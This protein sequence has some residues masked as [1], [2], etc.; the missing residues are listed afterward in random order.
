VFVLSLVGSVIAGVLAGLWAL[1]SVPGVCAVVWIFI[2]LVSQDYKVVDLVVVSSEQVLE[3]QRYYWY[4]A[5]RKQVQTIE[6]RHILRV[7][8]RVTKR[9]VMR[10]HRNGAQFFSHFHHSYSVVIEL[11]SGD[12]LELPIIYAGQSLA[13]ERERRLIR[14]FRLEIEAFHS[15]RH[16]QH[17]PPTDEGDEGASGSQSC[18]E[19]VHEGQ[20]LEMVEVEGQDYDGGC[21]GGSFGGS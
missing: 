3:I 10:R 9:R 17:L 1:I 13:G 4:T 14:R 11:K 19:V 8:I 20:D 15:H 6:F 16:H 12:R 18:E 21:S 2:L 7:F 5:C